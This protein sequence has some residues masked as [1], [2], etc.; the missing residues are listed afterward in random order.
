MECD[1]FYNSSSA[2][3]LHRFTSK[4]RHTAL[5]LVPHPFKIEASLQNSLSL[6][7]NIFAF[8]GHFSVY[9]LPFAS[10]SFG[11]TGVQL[12]LAVC[13]A[14]EYREGRHSRGLRQLKSAVPPKANDLFFVPVYANVSQSERSCPKRSYRSG[15]NGD[16]LPQMWR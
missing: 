7:V 15:E 14:S 4:K 6:H 12:Q 13:G 5:V 10:T 9:G 16:G 1:L 11:C 3:R 2:S 8:F